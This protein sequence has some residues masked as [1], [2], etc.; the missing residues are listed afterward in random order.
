M[1]KRSIVNRLTKNYRPEQGGKC[2]RPVPQLCQ[3]GPPLPKEQSRRCLLMPWEPSRA[4]SN[5]PLVRA[6]QFMIHLPLRWQRARCVQPA[7][8][9]DDK[10]FA[11]FL[12]EFSE[13]PAA[14]DNCSGVCAK[15]RRPSFL[16]SGGL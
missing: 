11:E 4:H 15:R 13:A 7:V 12:E 8:R 1:K 16:C 6:A 2:K 9:L 3:R 14:G 10:S 5:R